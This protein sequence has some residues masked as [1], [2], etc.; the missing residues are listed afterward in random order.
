MINV[1]YAFSKLTKLRKK[2]SKS[3]KHSPYIEFIRRRKIYEWKQ[4]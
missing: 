2:N 4:K 1:K 3:Q